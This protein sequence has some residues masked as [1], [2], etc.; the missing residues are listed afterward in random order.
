MAKALLIAEKPSL[1]RTIQ[2]VYD[3]HKSE[4]PYEIK[5]TSQRGHLVTLMLPSELDEEQKHWKWENLPFHPEEHGGFKY[6]VIQERKEGKNLTAAERMAEIKKELKHGGYDFVINAGDPDQ[7]GELLVR[8]ALEYAGNKIPVKRFWT[9]DLTEKPVL[10][11]LKN[12]LDDERDPFCTNL[13]AAAKGRQHS[14][15]RFSMN[16]SEAASLA[17]NA[18]VACGRVKTPILSIVCKREEEIRNFKPKTVYGV[19]AEY[20][21]GFSGILFDKTAASAEEDADEDR[22]NGTVWFETKAEA[23]DFVKTLG[24]KATVLAFEKKKTETHAPSAHSSYGRRM[25]HTDTQRK[26]KRN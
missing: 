10:D 13:Y 2:G 20:T 19:K 6:K 15:Y 16:L 1:M 7:E 11:A 14:D 3:K 9:N 21:E 18:R 22:K 12:L 4:I 23:E 24:D 5:F 8:I 26:T 25:A 17:M